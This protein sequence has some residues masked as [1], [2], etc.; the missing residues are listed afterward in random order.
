MTHKQLPI[1]EDN[2]HTLIF[3]QKY[4]LVFEKSDFFD[5][6]F[7]NFE[8]S[9]NIFL[10]DEKIVFDYFVYD[11][12]LEQGE[13]IFSKPLAGILFKIWIRSLRE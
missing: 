4:F 2:R 10:H 3:R 8:I 11:L 7:E 5:L 12:V 13:V 6:F 9:K 1:A